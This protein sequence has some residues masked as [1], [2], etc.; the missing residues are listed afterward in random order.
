MIVHHDR[1]RLAWSVHRQHCG[2]MEL[3]RHRRLSIS[4]LI[5]AGSTEPWLLYSLN[6]LFGVAVLIGNHSITAMLGVWRLCFLSARR[7]ENGGVKFS[8]RSSAPRLSFSVANRFLASLA[9]HTHGL[10]HSHGKRRCF[11]L[12]ITVSVL[13]FVNIISSYFLVSVQQASH[14][15]LMAVQ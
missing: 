2:T 8:F 11:A 12:C 13:L 7:H 6:F 1:A 10:V 3:T 15:G 4:S 14:W 5:P 9:R